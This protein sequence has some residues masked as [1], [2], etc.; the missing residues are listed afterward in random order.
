MSDGLDNINGD[1]IKLNRGILKWEWYSNVNTCRL[2][3]HMLLKA[4]WKD[5]KFQGEII[6]RGS[7]VSSLQILSNETALT[8][9]EIR[10]AISHLKLTGEITSKSHSKYTVFTVIRY[11][12]YQDDHT[13]DNIQSTSNSQ[14]INTLLTTIEEEKKERSEEGKKRDIILQ[15]YNQIVDMYNSICLTLPKCKKLTEPRKALIRNRLAEYS[16]ADI[17]KAFELSEESNF[18]SG[19]NGIWVNGANFDWIL[20]SSNMVKILEGNYVNRMQKEQPCKS[21]NKFN[22]FEQNQY[23]FDQ[24]EKELMEN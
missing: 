6:K 3:V 1:F 4:N 8:I 5:G 18:L 15:E 13:Q 12:D 9:N 24:L 17:Q 21:T 22:Q 7:F 10:T 19:R 23:D 16:L 14:P 20:N 2:F 11:N